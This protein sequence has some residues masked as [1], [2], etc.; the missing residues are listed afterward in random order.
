MP[1]GSINFPAV[2]TYCA[3]AFP[4]KHTMLHALAVSPQQQAQQQ[5]HEDQDGVL[6]HV[7]FRGA[8]IEDVAQ[9]VQVSQR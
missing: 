2:S 1:L 8:C 4:L 6:P 5:A 9:Y 7:G 3:Q